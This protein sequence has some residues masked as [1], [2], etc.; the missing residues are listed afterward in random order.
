MTTNVIIEPVSN[1]GVFFVKKHGA[2]FML[3]PP[4]NNY[5]GFKGGLPVIEI[6]S[7][8]TEKKHTVFVAHDQNFVVKFLPI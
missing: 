1:Y 3:M 5:Y 2:E 7:V 6:K 8:N 4:K